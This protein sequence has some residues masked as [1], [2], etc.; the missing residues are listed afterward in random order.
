MNIRKQK[1]WVVWE[2]NWEKCLFNCKPIFSQ[3]SRTAK[4]YVYC[5]GVINNKIQSLAKSLEP[6]IIMDPFIGE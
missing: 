3:K 1:T 5:M 4:F 6:P 2:A